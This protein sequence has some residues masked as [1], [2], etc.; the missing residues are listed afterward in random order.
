MKKKTMVVA[1]VLCI[2]LGSLG[3]NASAPKKEQNIHKDESC[4]PHLKK[5]GR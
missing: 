1:I 5:N 2:V 4:P 3:V